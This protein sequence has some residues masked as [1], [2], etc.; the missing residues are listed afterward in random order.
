MSSLNVEA[1]LQPCFLLSLTSL[2]LW[3]EKMGGEDLESM[4]LEWGLESVILKGAQMSGIW[5]RA[6]PPPKSS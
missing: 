4:A 3:D 1:S 2:E 6:P 5:N